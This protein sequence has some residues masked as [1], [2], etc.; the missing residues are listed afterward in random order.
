[1]RELLRK[2]AAYKIIAGDKKENM[3]SHAYLV[4]SA[5]AD[6]LGDYLTELAKLIVCKNTGYC[7][8]CRDCKLITSHIHSDVIFYPKDKKLSVADADE[9]VSES[10]VKPLELEKKIFVIDKIESLNQYQNKLLKTIEEPPKNVILLMGASREAAVLP[11][12]RSRVKTINIPP[13]TR[14]ELLSYGKTVYDDKSRLEIAVSLADGKV[15]ELK[16]FYADETAMELYSLC[17]SCLRSMRSASDVLYYASKLADYKISDA[18][19]IF[20][21]LLGKIGR[22]ICSTEEK[23]GKIG[24]AASFFTIGAVADIVDRLNE[25]EKSINFN[26]NKTMLIDEVL[27]AIMEGKH[28]WQRLSV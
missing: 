24:E 28:R 16:R 20:K 17:V 11:T 3:L 21:V 25:L 6:M 15:G 26:G 1:M 27:F 2:T 9:I 4:T 7:N 18:I 5:D 23:K 12:I 14:N 10:I 13:F 22:M 19:N 8:E